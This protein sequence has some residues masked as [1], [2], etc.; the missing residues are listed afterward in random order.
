MFLLFSSPF[1][2]LLFIVWTGGA[3]EDPI[4]KGIYERLTENDSEPAV[5][6]FI[7]FGHVTLLVRQEWIDLKQTLLT[8]RRDKRHKTI[9]LTG[10]TGRGKSSFVH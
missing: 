6:T 10:T 7:T 1:L 4:I 3:V 2:I 9:F 5:D 8:E